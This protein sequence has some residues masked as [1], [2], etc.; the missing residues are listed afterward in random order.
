[1]AFGGLLDIGRPVWGAT[2]LAEDAMQDVVS[3]HAPV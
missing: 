1:M 3:I 2:V